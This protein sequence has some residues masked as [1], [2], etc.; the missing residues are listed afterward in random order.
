MNYINGIPTI[1]IQVQTWLTQQNSL[2]TNIKE[3]SFIYESLK[4]KK[5]KKKYNERRD[6]EKKERKREICQ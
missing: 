4:K 1:N 5:K 2:N 3:E 6:K